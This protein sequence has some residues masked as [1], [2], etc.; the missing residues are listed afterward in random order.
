LTNLSIPLKS[1][2]P[3]FPLD[4]ALCPR[5]HWQ[6]GDFVID[7]FSRKI[8]NSSDPAGGAV[9]L[10]SHGRHL[11]HVTHPRKPLLQ[12]IVFNNETCPA[13]LVAMKE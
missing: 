2:V 6:D 5:F 3:N 4:H 7:R 13:L 8:Q 10:A 9:P 12:P 1:K 11:T